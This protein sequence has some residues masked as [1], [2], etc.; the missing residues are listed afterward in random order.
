MRKIIYAQLTSIDGYIED[1]DGNIGWTKPDEVLHRHFNDLEKNL[2]LNFYGR[3]MSEAMDYWLTADR[4]P[5]LEPYE[6][7]Y[8][9]LWNETKRMVF[10]T[11]LETVHGNAVLRRNVD[12]DE[13]LDLK[14]QPGMNMSVGGANLASAFIQH[15][16][17]DEIR[18]YIHPVILGGGKP[19]FPFQKEIKLNFVESKLFPG[20]V[21]M[22]N[23]QLKN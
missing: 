13:I 6:Y 3:G 10:S 1:A 11:T 4:L 18:V 19:M 17:V 7:E 14:N 12:V 9:R 2:E 15:G 8:A 21:V 22:L 16:L 5:D 20:N 23:Y